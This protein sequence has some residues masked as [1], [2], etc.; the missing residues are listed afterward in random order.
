MTWGIL[1]TTGRTTSYSVNNDPNAD[2]YECVGQ[3]QDEV[4]KND[5]EG[6]TVAPG[7]KMQINSRPRPETASGFTGSL[8]LVDPSTGEIIRSL[9]WDCPRGSDK[10]TWTVSGSN[11]QWT[12][13]HSEPSLESGGL[14]MIKVD[15]KKIT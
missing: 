14:G 2:V 3:I 4:D 8:D 11:L 15:M 13:E 12:V 6:E 10:N 7:Q 9:Y 1:Y 5:Y